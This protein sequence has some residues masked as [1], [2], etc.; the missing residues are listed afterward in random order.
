MSN[1]LLLI[2]YKLLACHFMGDYVLQL[3]YI[4]QTKD[5]NLWHMVAHCILYTVP[6]A[7][8]FGIDWRLAVILISHFII[9]SAK[10]RWR[11]IGYAVDQAGHLLICGVYLLT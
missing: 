1:K 2:L 10:A 9:D 7:L 3:D 11:V 6:F 5:K 8:T 4:A